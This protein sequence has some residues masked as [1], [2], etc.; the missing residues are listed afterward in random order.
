M[1]ELG[2]DC[3]RDCSV[4]LCSDTILCSLCAVHVLEPSPGAAPS[5]RVRSAGCSHAVAAR[6]ASQPGEA[7]KHGDLLL[8]GL[9]RLRRYV[10]AGV[11]Q[12]VGA[13]MDQSDYVQ[14]FYNYQIAIMY[15]LPRLE[16][17]CIE[18]F[19]KHLVNVIDTQEF[20]ELVQ[21]SAYSIEERQ[22]TDSIP[23]LDEVRFHVARL[24]RNDPQGERL[25]LDLL[26]D[27][28]ERLHL[29]A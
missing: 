23:F 24:Y 16:N 25:A 21:E 3:A 5:A 8:A 28:L 18:L 22:E 4:L 29:S 2:A 13:I 10:L 17:H 1:W 26:D 15:N 9:G 19:A 7:T 27:L 20:S 12:C 14:I 6:R 11:W